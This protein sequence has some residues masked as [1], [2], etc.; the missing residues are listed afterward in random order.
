MREGKVTFVYG[1]REEAINNAVALKEY[2]S[3][4]KR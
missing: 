2:L 3:A 4:K 1:S